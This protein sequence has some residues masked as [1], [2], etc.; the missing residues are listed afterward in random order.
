MLNFSQLSGTGIYFFYVVRIVWLFYGGKLPG[1]IFVYVRTFSEYKTEIYVGE[2][3]SLL[4]TE[5]RNEITFPSDTKNTISWKFLSKD[6]CSTGDQ[7]II[8]GLQIFLDHISSWTI[9]QQFVMT[10]TH[11]PRPAVP[12]PLPFLSFVLSVFRSYRHSIFQS[13][14][15]CIFL[16]FYLCLCLSLLILVHLRSSKFFWNHLIHM[17]LIDGA[18]WLTI[19]NT[20]LEFC[21]MFTSGRNMDWEKKNVSRWIF[22][23]IGTW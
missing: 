18:H 8:L 9:D 7:T 11:H 17:L 21:N 1:K 5:Q 16:S 4:D 19:S 3:F 2:S 13:F 22:F 23:E 12:S 14:C 20:L 10:Y 6:E 15:L